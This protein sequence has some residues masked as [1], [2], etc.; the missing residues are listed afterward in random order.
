MESATKPLNECWRD[1]PTT[2][3]TVS[4]VIEDGEVDPSFEDAQFLH[5][6]G[7]KLPEDGDS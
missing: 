7:V 6:M 1:C 4:I 3:S 5:S 2:T